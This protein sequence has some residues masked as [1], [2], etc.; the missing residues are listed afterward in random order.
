[1][2]D[3]ELVIKMPKGLKNDFESEQWTALSCME[4]KNVLENATPLPKGHGRLIDETKIDWLTDNSGKKFTF[5]ERIKNTSPTI[6]EADKTESDGSKTEKF[7]PCPFC[8][9]EAQLDNIDNGNN[10][11][12]YS[13]VCMKPMCRCG[14]SSTDY[15]YYNEKDAIEAWN[16]RT[17]SEDRNEN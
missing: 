10:G 4:M 8:G 11:W 2:A 14:V 6:I 5:E 16:R 15:S 17:E 12:W 13:V 9:S 7:K 1:M 3:I